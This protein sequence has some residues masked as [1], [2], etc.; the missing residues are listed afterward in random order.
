M[1][2]TL[3]IDGIMYSFYNIHIIVQLHNQLNNNNFIILNLR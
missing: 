2:N 1:Y 3:G